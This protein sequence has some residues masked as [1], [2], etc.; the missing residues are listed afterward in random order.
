MK[1]QHTSNLG[2]HVF[3]R[4]RNLKIRDP[5]IWKLEKEFQKT[6]NIMTWQRQSSRRTPTRGNQHG[7][8]ISFEKQKGMALQKNYIEKEKGK[9]HKIAMCLYYV[10]SLRE[11]LPPM[12]RF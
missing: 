4:S 6:M 3:K 1:N 10:T 7:N 9:I 8:K 5:E 11:N 2:G 12:K